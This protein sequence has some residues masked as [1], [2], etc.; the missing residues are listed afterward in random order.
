MSRATRVILRFRRA[1]A[2]LAFSLA[3]WEAESRRNL[4]ATRRLSEDDLGL[5][6]WQI[7]QAV[8]A[9]KDRG[10]LAVMLSIS[11]AAEEEEGDDNAE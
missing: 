2:W 7:A 6:L 3:C 8:D 10:G 1:E 4:V 11:A 5:R 9:A